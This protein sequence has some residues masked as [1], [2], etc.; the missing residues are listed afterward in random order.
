MWPGERARPGTPGAS[1]RS[2]QETNAAVLVPL[3][4]CGPPPS[5]E[6]SVGVLWDE[7]QTNA[8]VSERQDLNSHQ[9][10]LE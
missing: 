5:R 9:A 3:D 10:T 6:V 1:N 2:T 7:S 4:L 8:I